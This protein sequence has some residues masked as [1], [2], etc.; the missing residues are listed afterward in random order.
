[1]TGM[2]HLDRF[3]QT[4]KQKKDTPFGVPFSGSMKLLA[5]LLGAEKSK[6]QSELCAKQS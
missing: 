5:F 6:Y 4:P 2:V 1:M 3:E